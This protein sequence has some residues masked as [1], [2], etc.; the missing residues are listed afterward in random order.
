LEMSLKVDVKVLLTEPDELAHSNEAIRRSLTNRRTNLGVTPRRSAAASM[1]RGTSTVA[2]GND[3]E[4]CRRSEVDLC[5]ARCDASTPALR[6]SPPAPAVTDTPFQLLG[7]DRSGH[8]V[9]L[10]AT[11]R[12][13][14]T[15]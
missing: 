12:G 6:C 3:R 2:I 7:R 14:T 9:A 11:G 5:N 8:G 15:L 13:K 4:A 10:D 1:V